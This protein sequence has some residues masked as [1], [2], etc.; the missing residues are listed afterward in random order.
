MESGFPFNLLNVSSKN[1][2]SLFYFQMLL[3][4]E[5]LLGTTFSS[6]FFGNSQT[7]SGET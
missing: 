5:D 6:R 2:W 4:E 7:G 1:S 3:K